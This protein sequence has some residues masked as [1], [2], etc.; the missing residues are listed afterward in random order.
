MGLYFCPPTMR[1]SAIFSLFCWLSVLALMWLL[2]LG[3]VAWDWRAGLTLLAFG[4]LG[5]LSALVAGRYGP[6]PAGGAK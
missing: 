3:A 2:L 1:L 5:L 4:A 6:G